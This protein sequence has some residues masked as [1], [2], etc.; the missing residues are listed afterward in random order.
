MLIIHKYLHEWNEVAV[1]IS[2]LT[3]YKSKIFNKLIR[4]LKSNQSINCFEKKL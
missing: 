2:I 3:W 1:G 4:F